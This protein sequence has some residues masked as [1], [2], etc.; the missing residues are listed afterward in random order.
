M[1]GASVKTAAL[2]AVVALVLALAAAVAAIKPVADPDVWWVAAAGREILARHAVPTENLF[3]FV[4]PSHPWV[5]HEWLFGPLYARILERFGP[6]GFNAITLGVLAIELGLLAGGT[7]GR[8]RHA[9]TGLGMLLAAVGLFG[10]RFLSAR[11][12]GVAL[13][14]P[15]AVTLVAFAPRF[16]PA[17]LAVAVGFEWVWANAHGSFPLGIVLLLVAAAE[18]AK[19]RPWRLA[20][21]GAMALATLATPYRFALYRL[22]WSYARGS[23]GV[24]RLINS[25][26]KE[27]EPFPRAWGSTV[28]PL[29]LVALVLF[30]GLALD[31]ARRR[32]HRLRGV[33]CLCLFAL[34]VLHARH[35]ELAGLLS[36]MLLVPYA[37]DVADRFAPPAP[38]PKR[39]VLAA[40]VLIPACLTGFVTFAVT[41]ARR[42]PEDW[43]GTGG[44]LVLSGSHTGGRSARSLDWIGNGPA[45][46]RAI[47]ALPN[48][49]RAFTSITT[50]GLAIWYGAPREVRVFFDSRNDC[51][52]AETFTTFW[53][54]EA[55]T[56][57]PE[58]RRKALDEAGADAALVPE[59]HPMAEFLAREPGW[60]LARTG[61]PWRVFLRDRPG[62]RFP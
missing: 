41:S 8:A 3:S 5:M 13:V 27:F 55:R 6:A 26:I 32:R 39:A 50:A 19:D 59:G 46:V 53:S 2:V 36:C 1:R 57:P 25:Q 44:G 51:Y 24:Y 28:G 62:A 14:F 58:A 23:E 52:S 47:A 10:A 7:I 16:G 18:Q 20:A 37:D 43:I 4:E 33:F 61:G 49:A 11:P 34:A 30:V 48:H 56:T 17:S 9:W 29:D 31:A 12:S 60:T 45:L 54:L 15:I 38:A 35:L 40:L 42:A 22:V 21:A